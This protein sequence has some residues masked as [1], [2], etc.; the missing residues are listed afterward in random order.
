MDTAL[1]ILLVESASIFAAMLGIAWYVCSQFGKFSRNLDEADK[2]TEEVYASAQKLIADPSV[3]DSIV[4]FVGLLYGHLGQSK[5]AWLFTLT[6]LTVKMERATKLPQKEPTNEFAKAFAHDFRTL[7]PKQ[8][9][10]F[11]KVICGSFLINAY[12]D[13]IFSTVHLSV[14]GT[15]KRLTDQGKQPDLEKMKSVATKLDRC[16]E[17][18]NHSHMELSAAA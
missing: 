17:M 7:T 10:H 6:V 8:L 12:S 13:G 18:H 4:R 11:T 5:I 9:E 3:P 15:P 16:F 2:L 1:L 14:W